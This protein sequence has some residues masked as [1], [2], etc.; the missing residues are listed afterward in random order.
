MS[1]PSAQVKAHLERRLSRSVAKFGTF[2]VP[3]PTAASPSIVERSSRSRWSAAEW[4][5]RKDDL[6][7][8]VL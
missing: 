8:G 2:H 5:V 4:L 7:G 3:F 1:P 6:E